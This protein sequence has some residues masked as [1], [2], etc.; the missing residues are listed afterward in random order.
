MLTIGKLARIAEVSSD[1]LRYYER[2]GLIAPA[3]QEPGRISAL[4]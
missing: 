3:A 1:T 4:R 2:Q